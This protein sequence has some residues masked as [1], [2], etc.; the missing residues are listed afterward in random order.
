MARIKVSTNKE[1]GEAIKKN[2]DEIEVE[3][4]LKGK[5]IRI[6]ATGK[7]AWAIAAG[8]IAIAI[9]AII[10]GGPAGA[11]ASGLMGGVAATVL[12]GKAL[13]AAIG[14][15]VAAGGVAGLNKLRDYEEIKRTSNSILLKKIK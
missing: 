5:V 4:D 9:G 13:M 2:P 14:I 6:R 11:P 8:A 3:G 12:G 7:V 10:A 1:L 15:G